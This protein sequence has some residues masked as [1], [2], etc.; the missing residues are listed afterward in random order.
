MVQDILLS[1]F[2][3]PVSKMSLGNLVINTDNPLDDMFDWPSHTPSKSV[4]RTLQDYVDS[5]TQVQGRA[6]GS[7]LAGFLSTSF[8]KRN[9]SSLQ[10]SAS[11][12]KSYFLCNIRTYLH[13]LS[14][15][16]EARKWIEQTINDNE[17]MYLV[18][19]YHTWTDARIA[20]SAD[21]DRNFAAAF[22]AP[23]SAAL[24]S[25]GIPLVRIDDPRAEYSQDRSNSQERGY[26]VP[27]ETIFAIRYAKI[28]FR[29]FM[30]KT[31]DNMKADKKAQWVTYQHT[32]LQRQRGGRSTK[33]PNEEEVI[34][35]DL[36]SQVAEDGFATEASSWQDIDGEIYA[37]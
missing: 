37:T 29:R 32:K 16:P 10:A 23:L 1:Q 20:E 33:D 12:F 6:L 19:A 22:V 31:P 9:G 28:R 3:L 30:R 15:F 13:D 26:M 7:D 18:T 14:T 24:Q 21:A 2:L 25:Q 5:G 17:D 8:S 34:E 35:V 4:E 27:G 36:D 11:S